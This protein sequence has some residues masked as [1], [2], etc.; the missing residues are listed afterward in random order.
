MNLYA[1]IDLAGV[2]VVLVV[3]T[4]TEHDEINRVAPIWLQWLRRASLG[5]LVFLLCNAIRQEGSE[6]SLRLLEWD[7]IAVMVINAVALTL[8]KTPD[9]NGSR[10]PAPNA[11]KERQR[12]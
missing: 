3:M 7:G 10:V 2:V 1:W 11:A 9:E 5:S 12:Q 4:L 8:R 6:M